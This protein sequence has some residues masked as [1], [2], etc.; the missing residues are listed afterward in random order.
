VLAND[1]GPMVASVTAANTAIRL[2]A[3]W[4][5]SLKVFVLYPEFYH[6]AASRG[7]RRGLLCGS[8]SAAR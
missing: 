1:G 6:I 3:T 8:N 4:L 7:L 2:L 5:T